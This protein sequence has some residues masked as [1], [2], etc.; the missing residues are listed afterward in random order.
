MV[1]DA[2]CGLEACIGS[3]LKWGPKK[4]PQRD[5]NLQNYPYITDSYIRLFKV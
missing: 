2:R 4:D 5:P 1:V 3:S